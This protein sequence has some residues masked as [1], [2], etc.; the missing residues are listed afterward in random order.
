MSAEFLKENFT[1]HSLLALFESVQVSL[2]NDITCNQVPTYRSAMLSD[3]LWRAEA[4]SGIMF[5]SVHRALAKL[6]VLWETATY[7]IA[8]HLRFCLAYPLEIVHLGISTL[9]WALQETIS[10]LLHL[11]TR[12][13]FLVHTF[14]AS[15]NMTVVPAI[16]FLA[17]STYFRCLWLS[18]YTWFSMGLLNVPHNLNVC[19]PAHVVTG[20]IHSCNL[21][22]SA[23]RFFLRLLL[24]MLV[25]LVLALFLIISSLLGREGLEGLEPHTTRRRFCRMQRNIHYHLRNDL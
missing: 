25:T 5:H 10:A 13:S 3:E 9:L 4:T 12:S 18:L 14:L 20:L 16:D 21:Q 6:K 11:A 2:E 1:Y 17:P 8:P 15:F 19:F 23:R 24:L 22:L 7:K